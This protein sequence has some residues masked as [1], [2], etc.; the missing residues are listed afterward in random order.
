MGARFRSFRWSRP[1]P[2]APL[3]DRSVE[4]PPHL[5]PFFIQLFFWRYM[6]GIS[7]SELKL[8]L[9]FFLNVPCRDRPPSQ[10][11][12]PS[13][14]FLVFLKL[15]FLPSSFF[16][17]PS[18]R[19]GTNKNLVF[20]SARRVCY[21]FPR[22]IRVFPT[23]N[24]FRLP[25]KTVEVIKGELFSRHR[26]PPYSSYTSGRLSFSSYWHHLLLMLTFLPPA[27]AVP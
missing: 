6:C 13:S 14:P 16:F 3:R 9:P 23:S 12:S 2:L 27:R 18:S 19:L 26:S 17:S 22:F 8:L 15:S 1:F 20:F 24:T 4:Y 7:G 5:P 10:P 21:F 25:C 11:P